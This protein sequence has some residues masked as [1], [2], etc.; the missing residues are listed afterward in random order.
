MAVVAKKS[1]PHQFTDSFQ[2]RALYND[3]E[4][5]PKTFRGKD[6]IKYVLLFAGFECGPYLQI[7]IAVKSTRGR[8]RKSGHK[9]N[10][11]LL[12]SA[13]G[14]AGS[15]K[16]RISF[17]LCLPCASTQLHLLCCPFSFFLFE[18]LSMINPDGKQSTF[19]RVCDDQGV[20]HCDWRLTLGNCEE[21][22]AMYIMYIINAVWSGLVS[23]IGNYIRCN[24][25]YPQGS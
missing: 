10:P 13:P 12:L 9:Q 6:F 8:C 19:W 4:F 7:P 3:G 16:M 24:P 5:W 20:C 15:E 23:I 11:P 1:L 17:K 18:C 22:E 21:N 25:L 14:T 2:Q